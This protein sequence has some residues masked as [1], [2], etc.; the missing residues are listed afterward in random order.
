LPV[1]TPPNVPNQTLAQPTVTNSSWNPPTIEKSEPEPNTT[2]NFNLFGQT[3]QKESV[4]VVKVWSIRG[5][6]YA[7]MTFMLWAI[8]VSVTWVLVALVNGL[9]GFVELSAPLALMIVSLPIFAFFFLRLKKAELDDSSL[10]TESTKRRFSQ[11]TQIVAF[12]VIFFSL[13]GIVA[14]IIG[15][16]GGESEGLGKVIGTAFVFLVVWGCVFAYYWFDEHRMSR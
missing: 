1:A 10:K 13:L 2:N 11:I 12:A 8:A 15:A 16:M 7:I 14:S 6:E 9:T 5:V 3:E 4:P